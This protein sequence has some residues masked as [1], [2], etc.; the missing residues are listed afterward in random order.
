VEKWE[1]VSG[2]H[3]RVK[4]EGE[5]MRQIKIICDSC[6]KEITNDPTKIITE[7][8]DRVS[9][10]KVTMSNPNPELNDKDFHLACAIKLIRSMLKQ[11]DL[12]TIPP[13]K[14]SICKTNKKIDAGKVLAL[15][16]AGWSVKDIASELS[17][18]DQTVYNALKERDQTNGKEENATT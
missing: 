3:L 4:Q 15:H 17:C 2:L 8:V 10:E 16:K 6:K 5:S 18:S 7:V 11:P 9:G 14:K 1:L 12:P 13:E